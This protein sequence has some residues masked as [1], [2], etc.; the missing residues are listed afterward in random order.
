MRLL[1]RDRDSVDS[2]HRLLVAPIPPQMGCDQMDLLSMAPRRTR[3]TSRFA[4]GTDF[5]SL[6]VRESKS[7][8]LLSQLLTADPELA[9]KC[10]ISSLDDCLS[11]ISVCSEWAYAWAK[12][13]V[14]KNAIRLIHPQLHATPTNTRE[15]SQLVEPK[16]QRHSPENPFLNGVLALQE[17][18]RFVF[19]MCV[20]EKYS[21]PECAALLGRLQREI[22]ESKVRVLRNRTWLPV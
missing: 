10:I 5:C 17:F 19:V 18:D 22:V 6:F 3:P 2:S 13:S 11:E 20:L 14:I 21:I 9:E 8:Y 15:V 1:A 16:L 12:R 7:L 4:T